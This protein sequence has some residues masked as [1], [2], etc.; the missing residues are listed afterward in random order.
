[1]STSEESDDYHA[2]VARLND[3]WRVVVCRC[4]H[5]MDTAAPRR[6]KAWDS[7]LGVPE[8]LPDQRRPN[9][10]LPSNTPARS[11]L[12]RAPSWPHCGR[13]LKTSSARQYQQ[14][15]SGDG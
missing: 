13:G 3:H 9:S 10:L 5:P 4:G 1:M 14:P 2:I 6:G 8:L 12:P 11:S 7:A 15:A